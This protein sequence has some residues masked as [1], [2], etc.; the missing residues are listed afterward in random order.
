MAVTAAVRINKID[1]RFILL[2]DMERVVW[3]CVKTRC[4]ILEE[5]K[6]NDGGERKM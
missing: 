4:V 6:A 1:S 2:M 5:L 3:K